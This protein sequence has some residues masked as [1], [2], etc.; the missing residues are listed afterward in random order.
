MRIVHWSTCGVYEE[1][2]S[3]KYKNG[4]PIPV[5]EMVPY[6]L[7]N[8]YSISKIKQEMV[9]KDYIKSNLLKATII[10]PAPIMEP[11]QIYRMFHVFQL[12]H[13]SGFGPDI[14]VYPRKERLTMLLIHVEDLLSTISTCK[15]IN[16]RS[17][18]AKK[19]DLVRIE[20]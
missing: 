18:N 5:N 12:L 16:N 8:N 20:N 14:H 11:N 2:R 4:Y 9:L 7:F 19:A 1:P 15:E 17:G 3:Q 10:H 6:D 13:K